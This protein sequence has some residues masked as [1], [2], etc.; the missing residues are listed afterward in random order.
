MA[1][2]KVDNIINFINKLPEFHCFIVNGEFI[3]QPMKEKNVRVGVIRNSK[4]VVFLKLT[5]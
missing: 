4:A 1:S 5:R 3:L 2:E